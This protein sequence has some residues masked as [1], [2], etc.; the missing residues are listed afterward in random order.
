MHRPILGGPV[1]RLRYFWCPLVDTDLHKMCGIIYQG[2]E[3]CANLS[4]LSQTTW[5]CATT[6]RG[7]DRTGEQH[8]CWGN[9]SELNCSFS[10]RRPWKTWF[11]STRFGNDAAPHLALEHR[12]CA[13]HR[14]CWAGQPLGERKESGESEPPGSFLHVPA[15]CLFWWNNSIAAFL[16]SKNLSS[17]LVTKIAQ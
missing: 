8:Q 14:E 3:A 6:H 5:H 9:S 11:L 13:A 10:Q 16:I 17:Y 15:W 12:R 7:D 2:H 4:V 1:T